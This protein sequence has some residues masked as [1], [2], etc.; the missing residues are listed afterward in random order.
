ML[1]GIFRAGLSFEKI[2]RSFARVH[3]VPFSFVGQLQLD[4]NYRFIAKE[5]KD[6][7]ES[8][9]TFKPWFKKQQNSTASAR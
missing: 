1:P 8:Q 4:K 7:M 6:I 5:E 9:G 2:L 3:T